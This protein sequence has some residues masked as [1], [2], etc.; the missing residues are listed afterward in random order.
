MALSPEIRKYLMQL[1]C[2]LDASAHGER[3]KVMDAAE[4]FLG[5]GRQT[6]YRQLEAECGWDSGRKARADK[7]KT[8]VDSHA[9]AMLSAAQREAVRENDK[10][11]MFTPL[12]RS[13]LEQNG[14]AFKV[15]NGHLN[16]LIRV[17]SMSV[18]AQRHE[19]PVQHL[20]AAH[21]NDV[22]E[23]DPSLC[24][25]YYLKGKQ[26]LMRDSE[27]Y[28]NK[29]ENFA[30]VKL[31]CWR[32]AGYDRASGVIRV[33]YF[34]TAGENQHVLFDFLMYLWGKKEGVLMHGA[35][36]KLYWDKGSANTSNAVKNFLRAIEVEPLEHSAGN[37]R[38]KGGVENA[39]NIIETQF[40]S[41]LRFQPV[42]N[43]D[44]LNAAAE[45]WAEAYNANLI[46]HQDSRLKRKG[47]AAPVARYDLW[48]L[49]RADQIRL[50]PSV[51][52]CR[53][54]MASKDVERK[55]KPDMTIT[56]KHPSAASTLSYDL[57]GLQGVTVGSQVVVRG[58]VYGNCAVQIE[59]PRYDGEMLFYR[60]EPI[61]DYDQF[62]Q[63][64]SSPLV[65]EEYKSLPDTAIEIA[66]KAMDALAY[67]NE[68]DAKKARAKGVTPFE[69]KLN[70]HGYLKDI[71][72]PTYLQR[73]GKS[74]ET[75]AH[76]QVAIP[77]L[78]VTE[79]M[80]QI[81]AS[82][83]RSLTKDEAMFMRKS[84]ATGVPEDRVLQLIE[85]FKNPAIAPQPA[86][87]G[88]RV[89]ANE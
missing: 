25:L 27:F 12:A 58:L 72:H 2:K 14:I 30:K 9:L 24:L 44:E 68:D 15:S 59:V 57:K 37:A 36:N 26:F 70:S 21:P 42:D 33:K 40:E 64:L 17:R 76:L 78:S 83:K 31:K 13:I 11:T 35:P 8:S 49:I 75:P 6:I 51:E 53:A 69:G 34:E 62:G 85:Q 61:D 16:K 55:V 23:V 47:L 32:Y 87:L 4:A 56:F 63:R 3:G 45:A 82:L 77:M 89:V 22:H 41:R 60:V 84:F 29:L 54:L 50:L 46:P 65:G 74:I 1:A 73:E 88:L 5:Y 39:N 18:K 19:S 79:T 71:A 28:K 80:L 38:A 52:I 7:G 20:R 66:A 48:Q 67:P 43:I 86:Q 81:A 10:Q